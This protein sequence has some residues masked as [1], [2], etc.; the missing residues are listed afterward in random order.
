MEPQQ[1]VALFS[2]DLGGV[3]QLGRTSDVELIRIVRERLMEERRTE[4]RSLGP[5]VQ[6]VQA[7]PGPHDSES[8]Q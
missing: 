6:L 4:L 8:D 3:R 7:D 1:V 2:I 5:S